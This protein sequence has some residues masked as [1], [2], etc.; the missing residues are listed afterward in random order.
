MKAFAPSQLI[1]DFA[2]SHHTTMRVGG[3]AR[4][5]FRAET[6][7]ALWE[8]VVWARSQ[9]LPLFILGGGSNVVFPDAG[10]PGLVLQPGMDYIEREPVGSK[11]RWYVGAGH[12]WDALVAKTVSVNQA[13]IECLSGI[14]GQVGAAPIQNIGAYGQEVGAVLESVDVLDLEDGRRYTMA[15][16]DCGLAYRTSIFKHG[17][18]AGRY[19]VLAIRLLLTPNG[20]PTLAYPDLMQRVGDQP[21]LAQV[22]ETVLSVRASKSM[23]ANPDDP[24]AQSCGSFFT[25][26]IITDAAYARFKERAPARH[27]HYPASPG[28]VK[29]SAAWLIE[30]SGFARGY[31]MGGVGLSQKHCLAVINRGEGTTAEILALA[32]HL[33]EGVHARFGIQLEPEPVIVKT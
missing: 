31:V 17:D 7:E 2:L 14:P 33:Q 26:P 11:E 3:P 27:P 19:V 16:Q 28:H 25:N 5:F 8:A 32:Q 21:T 30:Q 9:D 13:G 23:V 12:D 6:P 22:R 20:K 10:F 1:R 15:N 4:Y 18:L 29:L 24:N